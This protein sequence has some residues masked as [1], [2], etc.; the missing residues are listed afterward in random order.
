MTGLLPEMASGAGH[1]AVASLGLLEVGGGAVGR[2]A[3][4]TGVWLGREVGGA[5]IGRKHDRVRIGPLIYI[6]LPR[7]QTII[8]KEEST[9]P[10]L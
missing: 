9:C 7:N 5:G 8:L 4:R 3:E 6:D 2:K 10:L 1:K